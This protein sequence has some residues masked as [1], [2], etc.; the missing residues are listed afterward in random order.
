MA[1]GREE[2]V[3]VGKKAARHGGELLGRGETAEEAGR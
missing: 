2:A 3:R 1:D